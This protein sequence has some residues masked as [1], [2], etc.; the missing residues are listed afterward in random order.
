MDTSLI[1][2]QNPRTTTTTNNERA[3]TVADSQTS[4]VAGDINVTIATCTS[5][6]PDGKRARALLASLVQA[7]RLPHFLAALADTP[8]DGLGNCHNHGFAL[9]ADLVL[10]GVR[11]WRICL[12]TSK[13]VGKHSW[14]ECGNAAIDVT[15]FGTILI[16]SV[17]LHV[18]GMEVG[19]A[20]RFPIDRQ[21]LLTYM[22]LLPKAE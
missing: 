2:S 10:V 1:D 12:G 11:N 14:L 9:G 7:G 5:A 19:F 13:R 16:T 21:G 18:Q 6:G 8:D 17:A 22:K 3:I 20:R 4:N 15:T